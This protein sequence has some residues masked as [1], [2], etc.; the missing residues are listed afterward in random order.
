MMTEVCRCVCES[1]DLQVSSVYFNNQ[2]LY[3]N[4][5]IDQSVENNRQLLLDEVEQN[6]VC[7]FARGK[8]INNYSAE[9]SIDVETLT[10]HDILQ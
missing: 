10:N 3:L 8:Q 1:H 2:H 9:A 6:I 7:V 5:F 4:K